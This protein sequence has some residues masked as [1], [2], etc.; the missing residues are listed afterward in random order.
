MCTVTAG[1]TFAWLSDIRR[2]V[3]RSLPLEKL[4]SNQQLSVFLLRAD[5]EGCSRGLL[6]RHQCLARGSGTGHDLKKSSAFCEWRRQS[7]CR[8]S[9]FFSA[10]GKFN[11]SK[12]GLGLKQGQKCAALATWTEVQTQRSGVSG[13]AE[14]NTF[15]V[16]EGKAKIAPSVQFQYWPNSWTF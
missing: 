11:H 13:G 6:S 9:A 5:P 4:A 3:S 15:N 8:S 2:T 1:E 7:C 16:W 12:S 10:E 14:N